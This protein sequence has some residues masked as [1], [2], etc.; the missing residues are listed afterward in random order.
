MG[1]PRKHE[2]I[3]TQAIHIA[4]RAGRPRILVVEPDPLLRWS[5]AIYLKPWFD[6]VLSDCTSAARDW[7]ARTNV[8]AVIIS[9]DQIGNTTEPAA[10]AWAQRGERPVTTIITCTGT[11]T[12][13]WLSKRR[14]KCH[15]GRHD[16]KSHT[17]RRGICFIEKPFPLSDLAAALGLHPSAETGDATRVNGCGEAARRLE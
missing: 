8:D 3:D 13:D 16:R 5:I 6:V 2:S 7:L 9:S 11:E 12:A 4:H 14:R 10:V 15:L 17:A 1:R